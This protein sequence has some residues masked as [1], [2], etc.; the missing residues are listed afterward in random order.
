MTPNPDTILA[1]AD[2]LRQIIGPL[3]ERLDAYGARLALLEARPI[4]AVDRGVHQTGRAY[5]RGDGVSYHGGFW[6]AQERTSEEP[7][8]GATWRLAVHRGKPGKQGPPCRCTER[9]TQ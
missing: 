2:V 9:V 6:I 3:V 8:T 1:A 5:E 4:G 7:G